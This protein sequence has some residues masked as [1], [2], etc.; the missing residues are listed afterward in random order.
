MPSLSPAR[1]ASL[2]LLRTGGIFQGPP[3]LETAIRTW[4]HS[5]Y[6]GHVLAITEARLAEAR[7][8]MGPVKKA[9]AEIKAV[10]AK[11]EKDINALVGGEQV[12]WSIPKVRG[13]RVY[14]QVLAVKNTNAP[15]D[16]TIKWTTSSPYQVGVGERNVSY[17]LS[18][19]TDLGDTILK[20]YRIIRQARMDAYETL[21]RYK[22]MPTEAFP[23]KTL[24]D[25]SMLRKECLKYTTKA[26][27]YS[28]KAER[29]FKVDL[30]GWRY[31]D[32]WLAESNLRREKKNK[33]VLE[34]I[35][36]AEDTHAIW[37]KNHPIAQALSEALRRSPKDGEGAQQFEGEAQRI[38]VSMGGDPDDLL[39]NMWRA[40]L[41][42]PDT[43]PTLLF[44]GDY[45]GNPRVTVQKAK[46]RLLPMLSRENLGKHLE[47]A[48]HGEVHAILWF[49]SHTERGG[50]WSEFSRTLEVDA[51]NLKP[52]SVESFQA[53]LDRITEVTRHEVQHVGQ[54]ILSFGKADE[55]DKW[56]GGMPS[57]RL[58]TPGVN[59]DGVPT[60]KGPR[61]SKRVLHELRPTEFYT[62]LAD[63]IDAFE[64]VARRVTPSD[65]AAALRAYVGLKSERPD[66]Q[67]NTH[68]KVWLRDDKGLW[69]KAV[70]E[71]I[72]AVGQRGIRVGPLS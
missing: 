33:V 42:A 37:V 44:P 56:E 52:M 68:F 17:R 49:I 34:A 47:S 66:V 31:L 16:S 36:A 20:V 69:R 9:I 71:L 62:D 8:E 63:A 53:G 13:A 54:S 12:R 22:D 27:S 55:K 39:P 58:R 1:V 29:D 11:F 48:S 30:E 57:P 6:A 28:S 24:V 65:R 50:Q 4:M 43:E 25:L 14:P 45:S 5:L 3:R 15:P 60:N 2:Y 51:T 64:R 59:T 40:Y 41:K 10:E 38:T 35:E 18:I 72:K 23:E 21:M 32:R 70:S 7:D 61:D 46:A 19:P 67:V 26:K